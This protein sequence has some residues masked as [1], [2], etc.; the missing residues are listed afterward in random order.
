M[1]RGVQTLEFLPD[2]LCLFDLQ[3]P[4]EQNPVDG[5]ASAL[6]CEPVVCAV[7]CHAESIFE[8]TL[9]FPQTG[10]YAVTGTAGRIFFTIPPQRFGARQDLY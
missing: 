7:A 6:T 8:M 3:I 9:I 2:H 5:T 10:Q 1:I 4:P